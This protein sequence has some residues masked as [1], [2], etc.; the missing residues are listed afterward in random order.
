MQKPFGYTLKITL[1]P[2]RA[3]LSLGPGWAALA[4]VL[5]SGFLPL[6]FMTLVQV[7]S[8][9]ILVDPILG[10]LWEFVVQQELWRQI[11]HAQL[12]AAPARGF[13]IP[14]AQP[15]SAAG[16]LV[17]RAR[18]YRLWWQQTYWPAF[19]D[20]LVTVGLG[21]IIALFI[22]Y[23][24]HPSI[25]WL[26]ALSVG[27]TLV[28]GLSSP[29]LSRPGGGR[30]QSVVQFLLPW[31]MGMVLFPNPALASLGPA[32]C[33]WAVY[34]GGLRMLGGHRRA[35]WLYFLGQVAVILLLL[36]LQHFPGA[37]IVAAL[38]VAQRLIKTTF[39]EPA[40]FLGKAQPY[41][42]IA[43]L[44]AGISFGSVVG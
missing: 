28:A 37:A 20:K 22:G 10:T 9:W 30:T 5:A 3:W 25:F 6:S 42:V 16:R 27:L 13:L 23:T 19:G 35:G 34:L 38:F 31:G 11:V 21:I 33:F 4:G 12:P 15:G 14:Y 17:L 24:L 26:T 2:S 41:L 36:A 1:S 18:G 39:S 43:L 40:N 44:V 29:E 7:V 32:F 8:L